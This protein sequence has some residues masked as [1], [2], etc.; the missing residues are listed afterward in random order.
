MCS[1]PGA[2]Y[3]L[4]VA[5]F[6][7]VDGRIGTPPPPVVLNGGDNIYQYVTLIVSQGEGVM[8]RIEPG[9]FLFGLFLFF[10]VCVLMIFSMLGGTRLV[11]RSSEIRLDASSS[12]APDNSPLT[13]AWDCYARNDVRRKV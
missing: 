9:S 2:T 3:K 13:F 6:I 10:C 12:M 5:A 7:Y 11:A 4:K 1:Q 8:A